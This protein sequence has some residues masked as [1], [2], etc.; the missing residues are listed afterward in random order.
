MIRFHP[1][2]VGLLMGDA[3]SID[4]T[5]LRADLL[6]IAAN[7]RKTDAQK[8]LL[9]PYKE[10]SLSAGAKTFLKTLA[11]EFL[12]GYHKVVDTKYMD[13]GIALEDA[14]I[15]FLKNQRFTKYRKNT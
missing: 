1:H 11:K 12:L 13:K 14:A 6:P 5:L 7:A 8:E 10:M 9:Q 3:Q 15:P 2:R 4:T